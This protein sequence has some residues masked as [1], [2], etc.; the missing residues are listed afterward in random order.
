MQELQLPPLPTATLKQIEDWFWEVVA[1]DRVVLGGGTVLAG[2]WH[3]RDSTDVDLFHYEGRLPLIDG[4]GFV[5]P[6]RK[7]M[8][9]G[10]LLSF[11]MLLGRAIT[12][13]GYKQRDF[14]GFI[15]RVEHDRAALRDALAAA[16]S[17][18]LLGAAIPAPGRARVLPGDEQGPWRWP[19]RECMGNLLER[20]RDQDR[21][22]SV[23]GDARTGEPDAPKRA[24]DTECLDRT[25]G[26]ADRRASV[27][28]VVR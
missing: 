11:D 3:H 12:N 26:Y 20:V 9:S 1:K 25:S 6:A 21:Q 18:E 22:A 14:Y 4:H 28:P 8:A 15:L 5:R 24:V 23:Q 19:E 10:N 17:E 27:L 16:T 13:K 2:R 7:R